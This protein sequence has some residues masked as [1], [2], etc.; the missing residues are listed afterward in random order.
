MVDPRLPIGASFFSS[1]LLQ[2]I[3]NNIPVTKNGKIPIF[4][5]GKSWLLHEQLAMLLV[6][7]RTSQQR[8]ECKAAACF[9]IDYRRYRFLIE[10]SHHLI[11][12]VKDRDVDASDHGPS[13]SWGSAIDH[14]SSPATKL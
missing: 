6:Q 13:H 3:A 8:R 10:V 14:V 7:I 11:D 5:C 12:V 1:V 4:A 9:P 2:V